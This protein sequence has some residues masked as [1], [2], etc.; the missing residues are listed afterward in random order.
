MTARRAAPSSTPPPKPASSQAKEPTRDALLA[1]L[2]A[3]E[4]EL[5]EAREQQAA[6]AE[7]LQIINASPGD[8]EAVF[9]AIVEKAIRFA[10]PQEAAF[11]LSRATWRAPSAAVVA[12]VP[13]PF[14]DYAFR[15]PLPVADLLGRNPHERLFVHIE[16]LKATRAYQERA[17]FVV[18]SVE[19][20][21]MRTTLW[22]PS[23]RTAR[24]SGFSPSFATTCVR[25]PTGRSRWCR[26]S[27][28][29]R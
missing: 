22:R 18:A 21:A 26:P 4:R 11:G 2:A 6:V 8:L 5:A 14:I 17:P 19:L 12:R 15:A 24:P 20:G 10:T 28:P 1:A 25:S 7:V 16:D 9:D 27:P 3:R 13:Q 29:R 23:S